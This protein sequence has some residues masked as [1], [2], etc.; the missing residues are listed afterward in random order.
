M[1]KERDHPHRGRGRE[2]ARSL[3]DDVEFS[4]EDASRT[5]LDFLARS[6]RGAPSRPAPPPSTCRTRSATPCPRNSTKCSRICK[7]QRARQRQDVTF[8]VHCHNDLGMAVANS[9][10]AV[11]AGARQV[12]CTINGIGE[13]AGNCS[14]EEVDDGAEGARG[15]L[16]PAHRH[17]HASAS[18][19][20]AAWSRA[21]PACRS[22]ATRRSSA[23]T[24]SRTNPASTST[25]CSSITRP[26]RS[27]ARRTSACRARTWCSASTAAATPSATASRNSASN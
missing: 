21:S 13:R 7:Q 2:D 16:R 5:E 4:P 17:R 1:A 8:S 23:R 3:C 19:R 22:R 14:L 18:I 9:L 11:R 25:A 26:T 10:A 27:C 6:G 20:P 24:R 12:E 15:H